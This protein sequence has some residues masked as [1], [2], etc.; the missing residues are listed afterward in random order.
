[1][2]NLLDQT[3]LTYFWGKI[4]TVLESK[5]NKE[6]GKGLS[7]N[8]YTTVEKNKLAGIATQATRVLIDNTL[9][10]SE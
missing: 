5:V 8:D 6:E 7:T 2:S 3:G 9:S 10:Q 1:M 4:K